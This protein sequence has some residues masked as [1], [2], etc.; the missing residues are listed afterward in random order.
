[1]VEAAWTCCSAD[2]RRW[3]PS[4]ACSF[5]AERRGGADCWRH[6][7]RGAA[8]VMGRAYHAH[9]THRSIMRLPTVV[10]RLG[11]LRVW[12]VVAALVGARA[13]GCACG[14]RACPHASVAFQL[15]QRSPAYTLAL[16]CSQSVWSSGEGDWQHRQQQHTRGAARNR[17]G[18]WPRHLCDC[19]AF[20]L[21]RWQDFALHGP[22]RAP[23]VLSAPPARRPPLPLHPLQGFAVGM[24]A[25]LQINPYYGKT[26]MIGLRQHFK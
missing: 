14:R 13:A 22:C 3:L 9:R 20:G 4:H 11:V 25:A 15:P 2:C 17:A 6:H 5:L 23:L 18:G 24:D 16:S 10:L 1:M 8:D 19:V 26:S 7:G 12:G 21:R